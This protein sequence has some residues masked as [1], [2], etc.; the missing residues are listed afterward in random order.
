[1]CNHCWL[2]TGYTKVCCDCGLEQKVLVLNVWNKFSAPLN[3]QYD[4]V[5]RFKIKVDKL[6]GLHCGPKY[7]DPVWVVLKRKKLCN[8]GDVRQAIRKSR[9]KAK[10][11]DCVRIFCDVFSRFRLPAEVD[12]LATQTLL[13]DMF[14]DVH[15]AWLRRWENSEGFF[16]YDFLLRYFLEQINSPLVVYLKP[17]T[18]KTRLKK[19]MEKLRTILSQDKNGKWSQNFATIH[20]L[21]ESARSMNHPCQQ[22]S[23]E[24]LF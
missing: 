15:H 5:G 11:Y 9:L 14:E 18:N 22:L 19:Y 20:S 10:H 8:P 4:R 1:M 21:N 2:D 23:D 6:I 24:G 16:S 13:L 12:P 7:T 17:K 3:R